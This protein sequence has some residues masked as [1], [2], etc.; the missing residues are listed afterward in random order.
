MSYWFAHADAWTHAKIVAVSL[1]WT[2]LVFLV[3]SNMVPG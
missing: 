2:T 1:V 3:M